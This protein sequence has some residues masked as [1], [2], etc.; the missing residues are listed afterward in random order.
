M[1]RIYFIWAYSRAYSI[2]CVDIGSIYERAN[3]IEKS[4]FAIF[5]FSLCGIEC[6]GRGGIDSGLFFSETGQN[7]TVFDRTLTG[8]RVFDSFVSGAFY[9]VGFI[10]N[11]EYPFMPGYLY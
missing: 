11:K 1:E 9:C 4:R 7:N 5:I 3:I 10:R 8:I 2:G 6:T